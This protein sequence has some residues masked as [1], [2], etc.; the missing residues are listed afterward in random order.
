MCGI[1]GGINFS[2]EQFSLAKN[3]LIHRG[4]DEIGDF[5]FNNLYLFHSRL[6]IQDIVN[7]QQP[8]HNLNSTIIFN[9]EIYNHNELRSTYNL[10]CKT[11]SD[12]ET[13]LLLFNN[14]GLNMLD[15]LDGMFVFAIFNSESR[16]LILCRDRA[17]EK[18]LYI[19]KSEEK[20]AFSSE[21]NSLTSVF[22]PEI[23]FENIYQYLRYG[24][25]S[26][27]TP[28]KNI[29]ELPAGS[30]YRINIDTL[31]VSR[32]KW[33][34]IDTFYTQQNN[35]NLNQTKEY[36]DFLLNESI[37]SRINNSDLEVGTFLSG[38]IDS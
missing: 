3:L 29:I 13:I 17:G 15:L 11:R 33:W 21:L 6:G 38:G 23:A 1:L 5:S 16:D 32:G 14:L 10:V 30:W 9:G 26:E 2:K 27:N 31:K 4:P 19:F 37:S 22:C 12:T 25:L 8:Y 7:G 36:V 24:F 20:F 35:L 28:Y 34:N 18:P